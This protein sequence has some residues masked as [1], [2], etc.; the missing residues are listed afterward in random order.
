MVYNRVIQEAVR[1]IA[2]S[3]DDV[4]PCVAVLAFTIDDWLVYGSIRL[5]FQPSLTDSKKK[6]VPQ[7]WY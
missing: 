4:I 7:Y 6:C 5:T 3:L 1:Q 2:S